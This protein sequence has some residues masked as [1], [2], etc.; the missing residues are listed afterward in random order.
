MPGIATVHDSGLERAHAADLAE[1]LGVPFAQLSDVT[2]ARLAGLL[3]PGLEPGNPLDV[4]GTGADT[5]GLFA[6]S[7]AALADDPSVAAV[8]LAVDLVNELDGDDS[9]PLAALD[10]ARRTDKPLA[11]LSNLPG[12][13]DQDAAARLRREA[14][15]VLEGLRTG[16][17]ALGHLLDHTG[18]RSRYEAGLDTAAASGTVAAAPATAD[19]AAHAAGPATQAA[20]PARKAAAP[21]R[22]PLP[23]LGP[24]SAQLREPPWAW[25]MTRTAGVAGWPSSRPARRA[26]PRC[27][28]CCAS[29]ES[30]PPAQSR[31]IAPRGSSRRPGWSGTRLS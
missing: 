17:L 14:I 9:Y 1:Q 22:Q 18:A 6:G 20:V 8:A 11:V 31:P 26:A 25:P 19:P 7:L 5:V 30:P 12:A 13:I 4:W 29:T 3:D 10:A 23:P 24:P 2:R 27:L 28:T 21:A 15:P 16:L